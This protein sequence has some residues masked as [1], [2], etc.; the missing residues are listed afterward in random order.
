MTEE[1][2][3]IDL[4]IFDND[5]VV[6]DATTSD[7]TRSQ[8]S[9][10]IDHASQLIL[11]HRDG[12]DITDILAELDDALTTADVITDAENDVGLSI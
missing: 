5:G 2:I 7:L 10:I 11:L 3:T 9:D 1:T 6:V 4:N 12:K 8:I